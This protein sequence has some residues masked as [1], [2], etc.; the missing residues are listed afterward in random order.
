MRSSALFCVTVAVARRRWG[1][2]G[3]LLLILGVLEFLHTQHNHQT[4]TCKATPFYFAAHINTCSEYVYTNCC[5]LTTI[6]RKYAKCFSPCFLFCE[7]AVSVC[8][9]RKGHPHT[10][11][12]LHI[13][14]RARNTLGCWIMRVD[15]AELSLHITI[16]LSFSQLQQHLPWRCD[17]SILLEFNLGP[18]NKTV[19]YRPFPNWP[20]PILITW[21]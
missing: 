3:E 21:N 1:E 10:H 6:K 7:F 4:R 14:L 19:A 13:Q 9:E 18:L 2:C 8:G 16:I 20:S 5:A 17:I 11:A 15:R 12:H